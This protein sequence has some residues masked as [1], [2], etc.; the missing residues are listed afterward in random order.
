M[1]NINKKAALHFKDQNNSFI[2]GRGD[3]S[4]KASSLSWRCCGNCSYGWFPSL[5]LREL[6]RL[7]KQ[8]DT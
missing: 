2:W 4:E 1:K 6:P 3:F 5:E 7:L 8:N